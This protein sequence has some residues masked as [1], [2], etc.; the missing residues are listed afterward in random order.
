M[1]KIVVQNTEVTVIKFDN[2]DYF[3]LTD[4]LKSK[5]GDFFVADW[6]RNRNLLK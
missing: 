1:A 4:M 2:D 6:L 3:S 5:D